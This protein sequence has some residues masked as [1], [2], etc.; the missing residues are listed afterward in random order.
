MLY[1]K[2]QNLVAQS[3]R[4]LNG[5][6]LL[7]VWGHVSVKLDDDSFYILGHLHMDGKLLSSVIPDN[8]VLADMDGNVIGNENKSLPGEIYIHTEIYKNRPDVNSVVHHHGIYTITLG[9]VRQ[10][11]LPIWNQAT[12]FYKGTPIFD[13]AEQI[14]QIEIGNQVAVALKD[15][16]GILLKGHGAVVVGTNIEEATVLSVVMERTARMQLEAAALGNVE[17]IPTSALKDGMTRGLTKNELVE[18]YWE[19]FC[20][21]FPLFPAY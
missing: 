8:I 20:A 19:Y 2:T 21:K 6:N 13:K 3:V 17:P 5:M 10:E 18:S 12:P 4:I 15:K 1:S 11:I 14:D 7:E 16:Q 9:A